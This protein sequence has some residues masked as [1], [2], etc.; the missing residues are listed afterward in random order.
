[1]ILKDD[2]AVRRLNSP[3]NLINRLAAVSKTKARKT[4]AM[5]LFGIGRKKTEE[6]K[7]V[8]EPVT[9]PSFNPFVRNIDGGLTV[10]H[11]DSDSQ[12]PNE[13]S[14]NNKITT[15][16]NILENHESKIKLGLAHDKALDLLHRSVEALSAKLEDVRADRL[17]SVIAAASKTVES[18]RRE[19][20]ES[21]KLNKDQEVHY[22]FYTPEQKKIADYEIIE[23]TS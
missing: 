5:A 22:H 4:D 14:E 1:M 7:E 12:K 9:A 3:L 23:V 19:R 17:P 21:A 11:V 2:D 16:D 18:I 15:L 10:I 6:K 13:E 8:R 20:N